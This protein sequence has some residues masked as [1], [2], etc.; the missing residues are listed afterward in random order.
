MPS[1]LLKCIQQVWQWEHDLLLYQHYM[2]SQMAILW[3]QTAALKPTLRQTCLT[4]WNRRYQYFLDNIQA[5]EKRVKML[6]EHNSPSSDDFSCAICLSVLTEP[7][8]LSRCLHTFC[9][10]CLQRLY[11]NCSTPGCPSS[12]HRKRGPKYD[13]TWVIGCHCP[14]RCFTTRHACPLCR[15]PFSL[16]DCRLDIALDN[17]I[18]LY[19]PQ[20]R[21]ASRRQR[22]VLRTAVQQFRFSAAPLHSKEKGTFSSLS[23]QQQQRRQH[24]TPR[25]RQTQIS[26]RPR[27]H[28]NRPRPSPVHPQTPEA[29]Y[30]AVTS[31]L[32]N[33][34]RHSWWF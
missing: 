12:C 11:C 21:P 18:T 16:R 31:E 7:V 17:F 4:R 23:Q 22:S 13:R 6:L 29:G 28:P 3:D 19:F 2:D 14:S 32:Y 5:L 34:A 15:T 20:E 26:S 33:T 1:E 9:R 24:S 8:T 27:H 25:R 30:Q 10:S